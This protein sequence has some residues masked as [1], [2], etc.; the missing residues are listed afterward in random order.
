MLLYGEEIQDASRLVTSH[1]NRRKDMIRNKIIAV[2]T[3]AV[4]GMAMYGGSSAVFAHD[5]H[6]HD[7]ATGQAG[8]TETANKVELCPVSGEKIEQQGQYA[9]EYKGKVYNFCCSN[10]LEEFKKN[11][12]K[13]ISHM[14]GEAAAEKPVN[15]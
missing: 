15:H 5:G 14:S 6:D 8:S 1:N 9:Y 12:E 10:C 13:Y 4:I 11:P 7:E 2:M 3:A